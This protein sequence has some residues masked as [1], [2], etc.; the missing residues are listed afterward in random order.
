MTSTA[1]RT[2]EVVRLPPQRWRESFDLF[3]STLHMHPVAD[4]RWDQMRGIY[5]P[6]RVYGVLD[7]GDGPVVGTL[8][9]SP[10]RMALPGGHLV[11]AYCGT[12]AGVRADQTR[13]GVFGRMVTTRLRDMAERGESLL[14]AR[15]STADLWQRWG[16]GPAARAQ[17]FR[18]DR[19][20]GRL[21]PELAPRR[22][23]VP[24]LAPD[25]DL[26]A[27][28][29][30]I[31][32]RA[33]V[34]RPGTVAR[35]DAWWDC[36]NPHTRAPGAVHAAVV[37]GSTGNPDSTDSTSTDSTDGAV[38]YV[39]WYVSFEGAELASMRRVVHVLELFA[40]TPDAAADLWCYL[41]SLELV[42]EI[43]ALGRP[44]DEQVPLLLTDERACQVG[45][46]R[47]ELWLRI[48]DVADALRL[49]GWAPTAAES[50]VLEVFDDRLPSN[51]GCYRISS[52]GA[53]RTGRPADLS[54]SVL[55]L[56]TMYLGDRLPSHL[57]AAGMLEVHD[58]ASLAHADRL[59]AT[60]AAP[61]GGSMF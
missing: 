51:T 61:W 54:C 15:P 12:A 53:E 7:G 46:V 28:L 55:H 50:V 48:V 5:H 20:R 10:Y 13:R 34:G 31:Q 27:V 9:Y 18:I 52:E 44:L 47:D 32:R 23:R 39:T 40:A 29:P 45:E 14:L 17:G 59:F 1:E 21:R 11:P 60:S 3:M 58:R 35:S 37:H 33:A 8:M 43:R 22:E 56:A 41:L 19:L 30:G 49:R 24:R 25:T 6:E 2:V 16:T 57:A 26:G 38:G 4:E 36:W 42:E